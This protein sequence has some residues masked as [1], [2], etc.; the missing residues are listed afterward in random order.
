[1][2]DEKL[3]R[4]QLLQGALVS[5]AAVPAA[6]LMARDAI[7]AEELLSESDPAAKQYGYVTMASK[8]L[9]TTSPTYK[10]GQMCASCLQY[11]GRPNGVGT[12]AIFP[13]KLVKGTGWCKV[14]V[15]A[16][17]SAG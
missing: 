13:N 2:P 6:S 10:P 12:C 3:S 5:L 14:W 17:P 4:R 7:A 16:A 9:T 15:P 8:T 1:M 11:K